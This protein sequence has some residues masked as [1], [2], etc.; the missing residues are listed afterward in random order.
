MSTNPSLKSSSQIAVRITEAIL[1][2]QLAPGTRLGEQQL[3]DLFKVSRTQVREALT[4][5]MARGIVT[6]SARRGWFVIEPTPAQAREA[7]EARRVIEL[8][9]LRQARLRP[10]GDTAI[11][12]LREHIA[13]EE[14]AIAG[15]DVGARSY[16]LGDFHV[17]LAECLGNSLLA[18]TLRDLTARTTLTAMLHQSSEQAEDSCSEHVLI[19]EALERGDLEQA[20]QLMHDHLQHVESGLNQVRSSDPLEPLRQ[21][22]ASVSRQGAASD[23]KTVRPPGKGPL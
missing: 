4:H 3:A 9:L 6:V 22:L 17:C 21:A 11:G 8:G 16:L 12:Q 14:A 10:V 19:V 1:A 13:R 20:E 15:A 5:L 2:K 18:E 23:A 7:F